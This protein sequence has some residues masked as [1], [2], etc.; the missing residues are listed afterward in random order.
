MEL[1]EKYHIDISLIDDIDVF[2]SGNKYTINYGNK[3]ETICVKQTGS[4]VIFE[5][6]DGQKENTILF[7]SVG[8]ISLNGKNV[9]VDA[10]NSDQFSDAKARIRIYKGTKSLSPYGNLRPSDYNQYVTSGKQ[11]LVLGAAI[12]SLAVTT[13]TTL[14]GNLPPFLGYAGSLSGIAYAVYNVI[15]AIDAKTQN[16]GTISTTYI[17]SPTDYKYITRFYANTECTG[18]YRQEVSYEHF[19]IY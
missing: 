13:L 7:D 14:I 1:L 18:T 5:I 16:I 2:E 17:H 6:S 9:Y 8:N 10:E 11:N 12:D 15:V 4:M 19:I 3:W